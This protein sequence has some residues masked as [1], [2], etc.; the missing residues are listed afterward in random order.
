M[1]TLFRSPH[2]R[3][4]SIVLAFVLVATGGG[5]A[6]AYWSSSGTAT[7]SVTTGTSL[8]LELNPGTPTDTLYPGG[9]A[10]IV[11]RIT[12]PNRAPTILSS[13]YLDATHGTDGFGVDPA[14]ADCGLSALTFTTQR[15]AGLGWTVPARIGATDGSVVLTLAGA[16]S[17]DLGA[18][19]ACQGATFTVFMAARA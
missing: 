19:N 12:N 10:S 1:P 15:N 16:V 17:M 11:V 3:R 2:F 9:E 14:H 6:T 8:P 7:G 18:A 13:L 4:G 5:L